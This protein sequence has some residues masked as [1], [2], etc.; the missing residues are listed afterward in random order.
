MSENF[1][2][3]KVKK[4][5]KMDQKVQ[6]CQKMEH[7]LT[8]LCM[9]QFS[10]IFSLLEQKNLEHLKFVWYLYVWLSDPVYV[11]PCPSTTPYTRPYLYQPDY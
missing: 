2:W 1:L 3:G 9:G 6:K 11:R 10:D 4:C 8:F 5:Q 7:L